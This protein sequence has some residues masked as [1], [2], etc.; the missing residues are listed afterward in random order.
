MSLSPGARI[1]PFEVVG[2]LGAGGMGEVY[3]AHDSRLGRHLALKLL[4]AH[5]ALDAQR[6]ARFVREAHVLASLN[7]PNI[8]TLHGIEDFDG[9]QVLVME[10]VE[11]ETLGDRLSRLGSRLPFREILPIARQVVDAL[12]AAH[13]RGIVHRRSS[14]PLI[15]CGRGPAER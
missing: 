12:D 3:R 10:L 6:R 9:Q 14:R 8:S 4:P 13:D 7:H 5:L 2:S 1:G 15:C 11:G